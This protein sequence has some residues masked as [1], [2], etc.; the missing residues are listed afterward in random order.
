MCRLDVLVLKKHL[1]AITCA[2]GE[3]G[4][5]HLVDAVTK[6]RRH[7]LKQV[8]RQQDKQEL[9]S[10]LKLCETLLESLGLKGTA[11]SIV[12]TVAEMGVEELRTAIEKI[13]GE[14]STLN[15]KIQALATQIEALAAESQALATFPV[16]N[17]SLETLQG[18]T[19]FHVLAGRLAPS[20]FQQASQALD[21]QALLLPG[22]SG[23]DSVLVLAAKRNRW[24]V[25]DILAK[26]GFAKQEPPAL[27]DAVT[28]ADRRQQLNQART[29]LE[30]E[31]ADSRRALLSL[32]TEHGA[33]LLAARKRLQFLQDIQEAQAH[34]G[35]SRYLY[36]VSGWI[37][38]ERQQA[39]RQLV[40]EATGSTGLVEFSEPADGASEVPVKLSDNPLVRPFQL[41]VNNFST[42]AYRELDPSLFVGL[43]FVLLFGYMF[44]DLGQGAVLALVGLYMKFRRRQTS[45]ELRDSGVMLVYCGFS[46]MVFGCFYGS[47]FGYEH[48]FP[49]LWL[50]P[51]RQTDIIKL[52]LTAVSVGVVFLS[53]AVIVNICNQIRNRRY[54]EA[55]FDK[56]GLLGL[57]FYWGALLTA[58]L[59]KSNGF[60][61]WTIA[62][63]LV[64][65]VLL[66]FREII[67]NLL[68][69]YSLFNGK[70]AFTVAVESIVETMETLTN[71]LSGTLSFIRVG[72]FAIS[73]AALC[74]AV[75]TILGVMDKIP[76]IGFLKPLVFVLGNLLIIGFEGMVAAIQCLRLEYY[77]L[78][79]RFF[80]GGG[81]SFK[82]FS[83]K[84]DNQ[85]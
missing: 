69:H 9:Q 33:F 52:L 81:T 83:L 47:V 73:H 8:G 29:A 48:F 25:N 65:L 46:A 11:I 79:S 41:L 27:Q 42:P 34:F 5:V 75:F 22:D 32:G 15:D 31:L 24:A 2:L 40:A 19:H 23:P 59:V 74:L 35:Y 3:C 12:P 62:L 72:A 10:C 7:L 49:A 82:H 58:L 28:V 44:G 57:A 30:Q 43:T 4:Y 37:P 18:L 6:S 51:L 68:F 77:E 71:Y 39:V 76:V 78:F 60:Q 53:S 70:S 13:Q 55:V 54:F 61:P 66:L 85:N 38:A 84:T 63:P 21:G 56:V 17:S 64:P 14:Y 16:Q 26:F 36:C 45:P 50:N 1:D 67:H 80:Q 20:T